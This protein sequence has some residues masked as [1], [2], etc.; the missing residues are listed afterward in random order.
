MLD[1]KHIA[2]HLRLK[3]FLFGGCAHQLGRG[4]AFDEPEIQLIV[5]KEF[6]INPKEN[7]FEKIIDFTLKGKDRFA[8]LFN[9]HCFDDVFK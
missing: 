2:H 7:S 1:L 9:E 3:D 6:Q 5:E 4:I 8:G